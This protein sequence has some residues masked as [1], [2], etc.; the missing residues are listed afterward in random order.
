MTLLAAA[1]WHVVLLPLWLLF[2]LEVTL[3]CVTA[4]KRREGEGEREVLLRQMGTA[5]C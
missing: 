4:F 1:P 5:E 3:S 2:L